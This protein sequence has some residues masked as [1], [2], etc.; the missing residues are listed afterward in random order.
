L[1]VWL[2]EL[3]PHPNVVFV[4]NSIFS[5]TTQR[6]PESGVLPDEVVIYTA[7]W[8]SVT[9]ESERTCLDPI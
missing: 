3:V 8:L 2:E 7:Q 1:A 6:R 5:Q 4:T 9:K